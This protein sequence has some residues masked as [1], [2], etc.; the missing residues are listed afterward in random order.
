MIDTETTRRVRKSAH[1][2]TAEQDHGRHHRA[3]RTAIWLS[4]VT[5]TLLLLA[6]AGP[7]VAEEYDPRESAHPLRIV[8]YILH[9]VG[10][11]LDYLIVRP[12]FW[13]GSHD[14]FKTLFGVTD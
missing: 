3:S 8:G 14:P 4:S 10:V 12:A 5:L 7:A 2:R 9:P 6:A 11:T 13:I 1:T